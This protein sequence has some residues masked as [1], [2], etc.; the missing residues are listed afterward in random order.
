M[1][2][3]WGRG[4]PHVKDARTEGAP[5]GWGS[6]VN[7]A[8]LRDVSAVPCVYYGLLLMVEEEAQKKHI[9]I[10]RRAIA[11]QTQKTARQESGGGGGGGGS[12]GPYTV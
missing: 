1:H 9:S 10:A 3:A 12:G 7:H 11:A 8:E 2:P 6:V 4:K 5:E